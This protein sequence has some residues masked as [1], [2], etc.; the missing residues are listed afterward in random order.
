MA[1]V[2]TEPCIKCKYKDCIEPCPVDCFR[3]GA[4]FM[5]IDPELCIDCN[6]CATACP[7]NAIYQD[8]EVPK[9]QTPFVAINRELARVLPPADKCAPALPD[10]SHWINTPDKRVYLHDLLLAVSPGKAVMPIWFFLTVIDITI[11]IEQ[12][13]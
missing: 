13:L 11:F 3:E 7:V 9:D 10:A 1:F 2:V 6:V 4:F 5:V 8:R 12:V